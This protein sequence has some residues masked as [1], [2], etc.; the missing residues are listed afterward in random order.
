MAYMIMQRDFV[1][2]AHGHSIGFTDGEKVWVPPQCH[3][4]AMKYGATPVDKDVDLQLEEA[5]ERPKVVSGQDRDEALLQACA[6]LKSQNDNSNFGANGLPKVG[7]VK[8]IVGFD[9]SGAE[10]DVAWKAMM[11]NDIAKGKPETNNDV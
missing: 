4:E 9:V 2:K 7:A 11:K 8:S 3:G 6:Y 1:I 10:R 5:F